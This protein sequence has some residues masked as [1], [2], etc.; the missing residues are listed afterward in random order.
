MAGE[1]LRR[2]IARRK[3]LDAAFAILGAALIV[4]SLGTLA[5]LIGDLFVDGTPR[6]FSTTLLKQD[7]S[8]PGRREAIG[9][10]KRADGTGWV[11]ERL[12]LRLDTSEMDAQPPD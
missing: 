1:D 3:R 6:L 4:L 9:R 12:E 11:L 8:T 2:N 7:G 10:I 5:V